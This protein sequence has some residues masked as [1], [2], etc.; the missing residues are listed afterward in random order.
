MIELKNIYK[1]FNSNIVL[2]NLSIKVNSGEIYG[3]LGRILMENLPL[4]ICY[5]DSY[6]RIVVSSL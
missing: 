1:S 4:L 5:L 3:L 2:N 6:I